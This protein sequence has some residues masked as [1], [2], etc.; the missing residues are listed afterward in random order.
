MPNDQCQSAADSVTTIKNTVN[1]DKNTTNLST[2]LQAKHLKL[3]NKDKILQYNTQC[4]NQ[5]L[6][7]TGI[8]ISHIVFNFFSSKLLTRLADRLILHIGLARCS[9]TL[10]L[11]LNTQVW[12]THTHMHKFDARMHARMHAHT[13]T[14]PCTHTHTTVLWLSGICLGQPGWVHSRRNIHLLTPIVVINRLLSALSMYYD[15]RYP[16]CSIHVPDSL[17][18]RPQSLSKFSLVYLLAWHSLLHTPYISSPNHCLLFTAHAHTI[19]TCI[20]V[21]PKLCHL[22]LVSLQP[23]TW[24]SIL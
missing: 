3:A 13:H 15:P 8:F 23:F 9:F 14:Q 17:F 19:T 21:V 11:T 1:D 7:I 2:L 22:I 16:P 10:R 6:H 12:H 24:N 4:C 5:Y 18:L 20:A